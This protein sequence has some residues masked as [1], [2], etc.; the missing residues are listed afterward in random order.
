MFGPVDV[1]A[2]LSGRGDNFKEH[3]LFRAESVCHG[4]CSTPRRLLTP[5][6]QRACIAFAFLLGRHHG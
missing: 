6:S 2:V 5:R 4:E 1:W 3:A